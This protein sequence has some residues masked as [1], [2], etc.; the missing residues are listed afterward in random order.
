MLPNTLLPMFISP[1]AQTCTDFP[2]QVKV[3]KS[4]MIENRHWLENWKA[5]LA[6]IIYGHQSCRDIDQI[7]FEPQSRGK[8]FG[9]KILYIKCMIFRAPPP[10]TR[11]KTC[12]TTTYQIF[13]WSQVSFQSITSRLNAIDLD[14]ICTFLLPDE[15]ERK[16]A[17]SADGLS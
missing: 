11:S 8:V 6:L 5:Y 15:T 2:F 14:I 10:L 16:K 17:Y 12:D 3:L 13:K 9:D 1:R 7:A 4:L